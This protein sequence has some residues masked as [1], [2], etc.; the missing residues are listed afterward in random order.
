M[1]IKVTVYFVNFS[2][3][4]KLCV[5]SSVQRR[6]KP[7]ASGAADPPSSS[8]ASSADNNAGRRR[9]RRRRQNRIPSPARA[10]EG[11]TRRAPGHPGGRRSPHRAGEEQKQPGRGRARGRPT[12]GRGSPRAAAAGQLFTRAV[13]KLIGSEQTGRMLPGK[14]RQIYPQLPVGPLLASRATPAKIRRPKPRLPF[15]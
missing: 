3:S 1:I 15:P 13:L 7:A 2:F 6:M 5:P 14:R 8:S 12:E 10:H 4:L 11:A 9:R